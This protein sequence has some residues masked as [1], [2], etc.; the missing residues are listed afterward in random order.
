MT[1]AA[2]TRRAT[3]AR[4]VPFALVALGLIPIIAGSLR[5]VE[6]FGGPH[7]LP[8]NPR[9]TAS[10]TPVVVHIASV[11]PYALLGALQFSSRLR[12][13]H[14]GWH[15]VTGRVLV[16]LGLTVALSGLWMTVFYPRQEGTGELLYVARLAAGSGMAAGILLGFAAIRRGD[17]ARHRA[18]MTRAYALALGAGTQVLTGAVRD[19]LLGTSVLANDVAMTS[20]WVINLAVAEFVVRRRGTEVARHRPGAAARG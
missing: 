13:R 20:A 17:V 12:R 11:I 6:V 16:V 5:L 2:T 18:W 1:V 8:A 9:L 3:S 14:P 7:L 10:P 4:W 19:P 15:R